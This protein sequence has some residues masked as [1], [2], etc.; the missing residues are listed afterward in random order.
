[1][2]SIFKL[3]SSNYNISLTQQPIICFI[4]FHNLFCKLKR[5]LIINQLIA[6]HQANNNFSFY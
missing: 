2:I 4:K 5:D 3:I 1:M 6:C